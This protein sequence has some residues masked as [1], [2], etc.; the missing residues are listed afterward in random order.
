VFELR[1]RQLVTDCLASDRAFGVVL[2]AR[3]SEVGGGDE[4]FGVGTEASIEEASPLEDG[5]WVFLASGRRRVQV[6]TWLEDAP[7][8]RALVRALPSTGVVDEEALDRAGGV[9]RRVGALITELATAPWRAPALEPETRP[10]DRLWRLC[11][12]APLAELDR[13]GLLELNT[14]DERARAL[15]A[16][17]EEVCGDLRA[18][19]AERT[20]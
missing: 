15:T 14:L 12:A 5:R 8:P 17:A 1:Y 19:L 13:Q 3:G 10:E 6:D 20:S 7:Y 11:D 16:L 2:I 9:L 18:L 4:R